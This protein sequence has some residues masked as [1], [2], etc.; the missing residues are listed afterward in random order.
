MH[1]Y[2]IKFLFK[3]KNLSSAAVLKG[4]RL[5][6][7]LVKK[8]KNPRIISSMKT[9]LALKEKKTNKKLTVAIRKGVKGNFPQ[10]I[11]TQL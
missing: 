1:K 10:N 11:A 2:C 5:L 8:K 3:I 9:C 7:C 4:K 6:L